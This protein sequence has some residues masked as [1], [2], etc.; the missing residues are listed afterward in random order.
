V[1]R[2]RTKGVI[3]LKG[4]NPKN[5]EIEKIFRRLAHDGA[6]FTSPRMAVDLSRHKKIR[7]LRQQDKFFIGQDR[8][9]HKSILFYNGKIRIDENGI[10]FD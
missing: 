9:K 6:A 5:E 10:H 4:F 2:K 1:E 7:A 3:D 8:R